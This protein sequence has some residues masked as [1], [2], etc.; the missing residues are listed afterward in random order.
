MR[1]TTKAALT[2]AAAV[3]TTAA[4]AGLLAEVAR[5]GNQ[6]ATGL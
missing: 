5:G 2:L 3:S 1:R 6:A 4:L